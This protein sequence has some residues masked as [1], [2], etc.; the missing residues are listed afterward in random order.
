MGRKSREKRARR[1]DP[2]RRAQAIGLRAEK[3]GRRVAPTSEAYTAVASARGERGVI[4]ALISRHNQRWANVRKNLMPLSDPVAETL[5][6][7]FPLDVAL[8][9][10]GVRFDEPPPSYL[11]EWPEH[12]RWATDSACQAE[13]MS[14]AGNIMGA[15]ALARTQLERWSA[16]RES[17]NG[18]TMDDGRSRV[19][20]LSEMWSY[21]KPTHDAGVVWE[22]LSEL[23]HGRGPLVLTARWEAALLG[24][25]AQRS[26]AILDFSELQ[27]AVQLSLRQVVLCVATVAEPPVGPPGL[28]GA[29]RTLP[30]SLPS[31]V[32]LKEATPALWPLTLDTLQH[33]GPALAQAG[34]AYLEDVRNLATQ[35]S[36]RQHSYSA[37]AFEALMS[38]R[39]RSASTAIWA[40]DEERRLLAE[41]FNPEAVRSR[42]FA[43]IM[44]NEA[45]GV[46]S[47][48]TKG[49]TSDAFAVAAC[50]LRAA[51]WLWLE[52]DD[53]ALVLA[54]T[55]L[56]QTA[57]LR[58]WRL[59][60]ARAAVAR[61]PD[62]TTPA[63]VAWDRLRGRP[64]LAWG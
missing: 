39:S 31:E 41:H 12:L 61:Q 25:P 10:A 56:E 46:L 11:G 47:L 23:L 59:K 17:S 37:R 57:R 27:T 64:V 60:P 6:V 51:L 50:A 15:A 3:R 22:H 2:V 55:I 16:N 32:V 35:A 49:P 29:L 62:G 30:L 1:N 33:F 21:E 36:P 18:L 14:L 5:H 7:L 24:D 44:I 63:P 52:D 43:Y 40:F 4:E 26:A 38:R 20:Q 53:R 13:R 45:A 48:W 9:R 58:T 8:W 42:E 19:D 28:A 54:R 34:N